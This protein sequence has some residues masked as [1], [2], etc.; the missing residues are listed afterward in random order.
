MCT[1]SINYHK[2]V[3]SLKLMNYDTFFLILSKRVQVQVSETI[4]TILFMS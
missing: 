3:N 1:K 4:D 2:P